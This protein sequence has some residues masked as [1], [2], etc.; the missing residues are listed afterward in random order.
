MLCLSVIVVFQ[1]GC[2]CASVPEE[3]MLMV[4]QMNSDS[5]MHGVTS[6]QVSEVYQTAGCA[7]MDR[8]TMYTRDLLVPAL[9][10]PEV[11]GDCGETGRPSMAL[12]IM[13]VSGSGNNTVGLALS[14]R[15]GWP[16]FDSDEFNSEENFEE[17]NQG[18]PITD[19]DR[20]KWLMTLNG[21]ISTKMAADQPVIVSCSAFKRDYRNRLRVGV[22][23]V[24]FIFLKGD[25]E[26]IWHRLR[27]RP[28]H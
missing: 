2:W 12:V 18:R 25:C 4:R 8:K 19:A 21:L 22:E 7:R 3:L 10:S 6:R 16:F 28:D 23:G 5:L 13:G 14:D 20:L 9:L 1:P 26:M 17:M 24:R 27:D 15:L 11:A